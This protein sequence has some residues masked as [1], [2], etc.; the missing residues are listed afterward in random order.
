VVAE[1][2]GVEN[3]KRADR[4]QLAAALASCRTRSAV[5]VIAKLNRLARTSRFLIVRSVGQGTPFRPLM[6]GHFSFSAAFTHSPLSV[7]PNCH[8]G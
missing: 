6:L 1:F 3:G 8:A 5:L 7:Q 2:R 4:P